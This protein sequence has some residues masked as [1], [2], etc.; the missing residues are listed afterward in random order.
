MSAILTAYASTATSALA[1]RDG[2]TR[3]ADLYRQL[4]QSA[5]AEIG[6]VMRAL[7]AIPSAPNPGPHAGA[8]GSTMLA[9]AEQ[10]RSVRAALSTHVLELEFIGL[11]GTTLSQ[12]LTGLAE[13]FPLPASLPAHK[14][15]GY[16]TEAP[17]AR[18]ARCN[19][20]G[21]FLGDVF[22]ACPRC[23][24]KE[25]EDAVTEA[26]K[27]GRIVSLPNGYHVSAPNGSC[28]TRLS[29][30]DLDAAIAGIRQDIAEGGVTV[31][32]STSPEE[33]AA[34]RHA[35]IQAANDAAAKRVEEMNLDNLPT[36]VF[37]R[38]ATN[39]VADIGQEDHLAYDCGIA[40]CPAHPM[41]EICNDADGTVRER[42]DGLRKC[43]PCQ[44]AHDDLAQ[45]IGADQAKQA[46]AD[47][48]DSIRSAIDPVTGKVPPPVLMH[49]E[50]CLTETMVPADLCSTT[51]VS[52]PVCLEGG[53]TYYLMDGPAPAPAPAKRPARKRRK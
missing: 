37:S 30:A 27:G 39:C 53:A 15:A 47:V 44:R 4:N 43:E 29:G 23:T 38:Q 36:A 6:Q 19:H 2:I 21:E 51:V 16:S 50:K 1:C 20:C 31:G 42:G 5:G 17:Q 13:S 8:V 48:A 24:T 18:F 12:G 46:V 49:C 3:L 33:G 11:E 22:A 7:E 34:R 14:P 9:I 52:C 45:E 35:E 25:M 28:I 26:A 41:C 10:T 40:G 32:P